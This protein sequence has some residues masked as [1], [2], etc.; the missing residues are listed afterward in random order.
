MTDKGSDEHLNFRKKRAKEKDDLILESFKSLWKS[1]IRLPLYGTLIMV[2]SYL[3]FRFSDGLFVFLKTC[4]FEFSNSFCNELTTAFQ[5]IL[6]IGGI[7]L[8]KGIYNIL[9]L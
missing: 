2:L 7:M 5:I 8:I 9:D 3:F 1:Y 4:T 6:I